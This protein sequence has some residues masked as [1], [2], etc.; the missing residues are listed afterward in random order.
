MGAKLT[1]SLIALAMALLVAACCAGAVTA[2]AA[3]I[4]T[5]TLVF[6]DNKY[7]YYD[8]LPEAPDFTVAEDFQMRKLGAPISE[9]VKLIDTLVS[10]GSERKDAVLYCFPMLAP[11]VKKAVR[12]TDCP[13]TDA[14]IRFY[15]DRRPMFEIKRSAPGYAVN[16]ERVY[17]DIYFA[18]SRGL[19]RV[20]LAV[21]I[22]PPEVTA[23][24]LSEC[25]HKV[26]AFSTSYA[27]ST[28]ERKH[29]VALAM[30]RLNGA[31]VQKG[32][33]FSFNNA[34]GKRTEA[35][36]FKPAKII[37]DGKY[38]EGIGGGVC[39]AS[40]TLY[41]AVL[42]AGLEITQVSRHSLV[43]TYIEPSF[44]AMVNGSWSDLRFRNNGDG[45]IFIRTWSSD[46][47][48]GAEIYSAPLPYTIECRSET[49][50]VGEVPAPEEFIDTE[51]KY[52]ATLP[53]G[54][55]VKVS[56]GAPELESRGYI[57]KRYP[58]GRCEETLIRTDEYAEARGSVAIAP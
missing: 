6:G 14:E 26:A 40:T 47:E 3:P 16:E 57:V 24:Q 43:P 30:S 29:N 7:E 41:N 53:S 51:R 32:E 39:Q 28:P 50:R 49:L 36:G 56:G 12:E 37:V 42:R 2:T 58:D 52:T 38:T 45:P 27:S 13:P 44:D 31:A 55:R 34:V 18:L 20:A 5:L 33:T 15:P 54:E 35:N 22:L 8:A 21:D 23:E 11:I 17:A 46:T 48:V 4:P 9:R 1:N 19:K 25:T 10:G